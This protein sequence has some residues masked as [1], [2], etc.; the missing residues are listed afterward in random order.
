M[1]I[2]A[3]NIFKAELFWSF[4]RAGRTHNNALSHWAIADAARLYVCVCVFKNITHTPHARQKTERAERE[5][6]RCW[7]SRPAPR[8]LL[9]MRQCRKNQS[10][11]DMPT[12][13]PFRPQR[14]RTTNRRAKKSG[15]RCVTTP[16]TYKEI[17][18][19]ISCA[20]RPRQ[21]SQLMPAHT[22]T[23]THTHRHVQV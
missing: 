19:L 2:G 8:A 9:S 4:F 1:A 12:P 11:S 6:S 13:P 7:A 15:R 21:T 18:L 20:A 22:H 16:S 10:E 5:R 3:H 17:Y 14:R 23:R